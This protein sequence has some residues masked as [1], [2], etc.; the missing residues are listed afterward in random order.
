MKDIN[1][2][3]KSPKKGD[4]NVTIFLGGDLGVNNLKD[5]IQNLRT[6]EKEYEKLEVNVN[7]VSVCDL[8][9][10]QML[11][12]FKNTCIAHKKKINFNIDLSKD[13]LELLEIS[14]LTNIIKTL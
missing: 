10:I 3:M 9:T 2:R 14:G 6:A 11:I 8:A 7:D 13:T 12:S 5:V 4:K 1:F